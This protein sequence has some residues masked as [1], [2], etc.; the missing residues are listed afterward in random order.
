V[1]TILRL[2]WLAL[3]REGYPWTPVQLEYLADVHI[4][5]LTAVRS[6]VGRIKALDRRQREY[7]SCFRRAVAVL[8]DK[9]EPDDGEPTHR[10]LISLAPRKRGGE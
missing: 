10:P 3:R 5:S 8:A 9:V 1:E 6:Y 4:P 7:E 2:A